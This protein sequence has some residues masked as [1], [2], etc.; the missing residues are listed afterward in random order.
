M[1]GEIK[2]ES[3]KK[4]GSEGKKNEVGEKKKERRE[5]KRKEEREIGINYKRKK[6]KKG[7]EKRM[8]KKV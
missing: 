3:T 6:L 5:T 4:R 1:K 2:G 8:K 7:G